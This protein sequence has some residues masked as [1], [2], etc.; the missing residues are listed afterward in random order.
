MPV[1]ADAIRNADAVLSDMLSLTSAALSM[2][3]ALTPIQ[4]LMKN[5]TVKKS[6]PVLVA[7]SGKVLQDNFF[8]DFSI[9]FPAVATGITNGRLEIGRAH[10]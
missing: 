8:E 7:E 6:P 2:T 5:S 3:K 1:I 4:E 10:V 9:A